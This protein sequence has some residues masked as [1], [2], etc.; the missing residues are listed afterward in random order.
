LMVMMALWSGREPI[1]NGILKKKQAGFGQMM[2]PAECTGMQ[3]T[4]E[5]GAQ[6]TGTE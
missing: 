5:R 1:V 2:L 6:H 4:H 3:N